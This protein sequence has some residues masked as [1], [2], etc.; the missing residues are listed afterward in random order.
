MVH[1][2]KRGFGLLVG[3]GVGIA[4][5]YMD[6][7]GSKITNTSCDASPRNL[8]P[9]AWSLET[10]NKFVLSPDLYISIALH[11]EVNAPTTIR[12]FLSPPSDNR[13][14]RSLTLHPLY[15]YLPWHVL[16]CTKQTRMTRMTR[17]FG[18]PLH[19]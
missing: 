6:G 10:I 5:R 2:G 9:G 4:T 11:T 3:L 15:L 8:E 18:V 7:T 14:A 13:L 12:I 19:A 16:P 1:D 17:M